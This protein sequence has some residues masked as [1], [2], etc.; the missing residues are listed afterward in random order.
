MCKPF[1]VRSG[2]SQKHHYEHSNTRFSHYAYVHILSGYTQGKDVRFSEYMVDPE[3]Q[4]LTKLS[5]F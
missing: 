4:G 2:T 3:F 5:G 1:A